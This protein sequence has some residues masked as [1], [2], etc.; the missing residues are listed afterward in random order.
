MAIV[1]KVNLAFITGKGLLVYL[2]KHSPK[3]IHLL[4][5]AKCSL[6][7]GAIKDNKVQGGHPACPDLS[8]SGV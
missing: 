6:S 7:K 4:K 3:R 2:Q 8:V 1:E 5:G